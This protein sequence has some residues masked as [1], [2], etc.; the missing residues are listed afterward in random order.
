[1]SSS[2]DAELLARYAHDGSREAFGELVARHRD[3]VHSV[4]VRR[5]RDEH[6]ADDVTQAVFIVLARRART[7]RQG[8]VLSA[9]LFGVT[10]FASAAALR[11]ESR[12]KRHEMA[13]AAMRQGE[14]IA[15]TPGDADDAISEELDRALAKL[16]GK[17]R[18]A[19]LLRYYERKTLAEVG[20]VLGISEEAARKRVD[21]AVEK[22]R[23]RVA[24]ASAS[25]S[26]IS[27]PVLTG[28]LDQYAVQGAKIPAHILA[29]SAISAV[30][31]AHVTGSSVALAKGAIRML[32]WNKLKWIGAICVLALVPAVGRV[33]LSHTNY[34]GGGA[35]ASDQPQAA[36]SVPAGDAEIHDAANA[37]PS[38]SFAGEPTTKPARVEFHILA[39]RATASED[40]LKAMDLRLA[41]GGPGPSLQA[42]DTIRWFKVE[43]PQDFERP[44]GL[45]VTREWNG[46]RY[47]PVL[48]TPEASMD[49]SNGHE[50]GFAKVYPAR[51]NDG[52]LAVGIQFDDRGA[53]LFS[54]LTT[55]WFNSGVKQGQFPS[56]AILCG[57]A[58]VSAPKLSTP[59]AGGS[60]LITTGSG[61]TA[62]Q[63]TRILQATNADMTPP[64]TEPAPTP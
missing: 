20:Q 45:T 41:P 64:A 17:D 39:D 51:S 61:F 33:I 37:P 15:A 21:R 13:A 25:V 23:V 59:I 7:I 19:V 60:A 18:T 10:R 2:S 32:I 48:I 26:G 1:M 36:Q 34:A 5:V 30:Q 22:L 8:T 6:L 31:S 14:L 43:D 4:A 47:L 35:A 16:G 50:W 57:D 3:W 12:R 53:A 46:N 54:D 27:L 24:G 63:M 40:D 52:H 29:S 44:G 28:W 9:W 49:H 42:G 55:R 11:G 38:T 58:I 62:S 56:L